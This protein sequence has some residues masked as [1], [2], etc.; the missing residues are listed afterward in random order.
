MLSLGKLQQLKA[1]ALFSLGKIEREPDYAGFAIGDM[2]L[3]SY[4]SHKDALYFKEN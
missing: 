2:L 1:M 4:T 3:N